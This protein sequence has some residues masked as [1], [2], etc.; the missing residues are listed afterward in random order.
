MQSPEYKWSS[1]SSCRLV[2]VLFHLKGNCILL[3]LFCSTPHF[4]RNKQRKLCTLGELNKGFRVVKINVPW[5]LV[6]QR[7]RKEFHTLNLIIYSVICLGCNVHMFLRVISLS[8]CY[9]V[10]SEQIEASHTGTG[11]LSVSKH[12]YLWGYFRLH[13]TWVSRVQIGSESTLKAKVFYTMFAFVAD[14]AY[15]SCPY[16]NY[17]WKDAFVNT[18]SKRHH[19]HSKIH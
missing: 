7:Q 10:T 6:K 4:Y 1:P 14:C 13:L 18:F 9:I 3:N 8:G 16:V 11:Q 12:I 17:N 5:Q 15:F 19:Q 2:R